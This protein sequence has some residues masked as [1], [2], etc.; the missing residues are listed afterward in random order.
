MLLTAG[1]AVAAFLATLSA[2][3]FFH[4]SW[5][6]VLRPLPLA[7]LVLAGLSVRRIADGNGTQQAR[8]RDVTWLALLVFAVVLLAKIALRVRLD[9]YGFAL[10]MPATMFVVSAFVARLPAWVG[11]HGGDGRGTRAA[12]LGV[13]AAIAASFGPIIETRFAER[14]VPI[15]H[16]AD[17]FLIE[18]AKSAAREALASI[19]ALPP[20]ATLAVLPEG[21]MF[22]YLARRVNPTGIVNFMPPELIVFGEDR[23]LAAFTANPPDFIAMTHKDTQE[24]GVDFFGRG[25]G[26][27]LHAWI[28]RNY[29]R[30]RS[31]ETRRSRREACSASGSSHGSSPMRNRREAR[32]I[33]G[34]RTGTRRSRALPAP[35]RAARRFT[36]SKSPQAGRLP[37]R[38]EPCGPDERPLADGWS[39]D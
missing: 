28:V 11:A 39:P 18:P 30:L 21:V 3:D 9:Q 14:T 22:N 12:T 37:V 26:R 24:Y 23:I 31:S 17:A 13:I 25:Y 1:A 10:A 27:A 16:G 6:D 38:P 20:G 4:A 8:S 29:R 32:S 35:C 36:P 7:L 5:P 2:G 33:R 15:G 34:S 19:D